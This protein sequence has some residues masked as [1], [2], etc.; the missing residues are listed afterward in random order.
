[1]RLGGLLPLRQNFR[2]RECKGGATFSPK[3]VLLIHL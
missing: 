3:N 1:V 2:G